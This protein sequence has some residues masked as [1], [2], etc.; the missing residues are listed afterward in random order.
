MSMRVRYMLDVPEETAQVARAAFSKGNEYITI[1]DEVGFG[2]T[3][4]N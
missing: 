2:L 4:S 1:R 3:Y